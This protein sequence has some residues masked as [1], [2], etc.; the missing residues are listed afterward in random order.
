MTTKEK[1]EVMQAYAEGKKIQ[2]KLSRSSQQWDD[3]TLPRDPSWNWDE[4]DFRIKPE[5]TYRPYKDTEEMIADFK[6]RFNVKVPQ[7]ALPM[8]W[9]EHKTTNR[10]SLISMLNIQKVILFGLLWDME[11]LFDECTYLDGSPCGIKEN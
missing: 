11:R 10:Q 6:K 7:Y 5:H 3:W 9:V 8:I 4:L 2:Y 1:V